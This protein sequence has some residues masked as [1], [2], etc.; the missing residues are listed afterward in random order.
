MALSPSERGMTPLR[1]SAEA[2]EE[3][4]ALRAEIIRGSLVM[5]PPPCG[6]HAGII[7][8]VAKQLLG[9]LPAHLDAFQVAS[10]SLPGRCRRLRHPR[11]HGLRCRIR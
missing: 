3:A 4:S 7:N 8:A 10:V 2:A 5:T 1:R 6:K 9:G 11:P